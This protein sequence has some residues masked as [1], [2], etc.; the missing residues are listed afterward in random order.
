M[1]EEENEIKSNEEKKKRKRVEDDDE[2]EEEKDLEEKKKA[3]IAKT[4]KIII[5][6][7][8]EFSIAIFG[9]T[10]AIKDSLK[11]EGGKYN[12]SLRN[13]ASNGERQPGW[14]F[15]LLF[16]HNV[17]SFSIILCIISLFP[18]S[19]LKSNSCNHIISL[20]IFAIKLKDQVMKMITAQTG[21]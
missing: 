12:G 16:V 6:P 14:Y 1:S 20:R 21:I 15:F 9:D 19:H 4:S 17:F 5:V 11:S 7:Y 8:S 3:K 13:M 10:K 2:E 18:L